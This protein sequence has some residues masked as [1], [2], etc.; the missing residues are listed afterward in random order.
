MHID[1][2]QQGS[3]FLPVRLLLDEATSLRIIL[4]DVALTKDASPAPR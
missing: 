3:S 1:A 4:R 2:I